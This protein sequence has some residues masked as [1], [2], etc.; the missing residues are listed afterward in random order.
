MLKQTLETRNIETPLVLR[1]KYVDLRSFKDVIFRHNIREDLEI[2]LGIKVSRPSLERF[3]KLPV[4]NSFSLIKFKI[5]YDVETERLVDRGLEF[6][7]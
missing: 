7:V 2:S 3:L 5:G 4:A 6:S 1:G